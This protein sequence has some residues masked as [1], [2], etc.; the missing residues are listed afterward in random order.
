MLLAG[1]TIVVALSLSAC[2][3]KGGFD[4]YQISEV[5]Q[6]NVSEVSLTAWGNKDFDGEEVDILLPYYIKLYNENKNCI[7]EGRVFFEDIKKDD[8]N[9]LNNSTSYL[10][11]L[12]TTEK[13]TV[14]NTTINNVQYVYGDYST[15][16]YEGDFDNHR[17]AVRVFSN[18]IV[19]PD[20]GKKALPFVVIDMSCKNKQDISDKT[21]N[22]AID[23]FDLVLKEGTKQTLNEEAPK[24]S[25]SEVQQ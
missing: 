3:Q 17:T 4:T 20:T 16:H 1:A 13:V 15:P 24:T 7:I 11:T 19:N 2:S 21:W 8:T 12:A 22:S 18:P 25:N 10:K 6:W 23:N 5:P 9:D 14:K